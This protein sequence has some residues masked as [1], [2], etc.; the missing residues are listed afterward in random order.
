[1]P[2]HKRKPNYNGAT[3]MQELLT[4]VCDYYGDPVDDRK[5]EDP[6]HINMFNEPEA[7]ADPEETEPIAKA[8]KSGV[9]ARANKVAPI[10]KEDLPDLKTVFKEGWQGLLLPIIILLPFV[11]DYFFKSTFFT[12]RLGKDGAKYMSSSLLIFIGGLASI[13]AVII[14]KDKKQVTPN[15]IARMFADG[16]KTIA[17][18]IGVWVFGYM[19]GA[20]FTDLGV[21]DEMLTFMEGLNMGKFG[22]VVFICFITCQIGL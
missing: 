6:D 10:A 5:Q 8:H 18:A 22:I 16:I 21:T 11:L 9:S 12:E 20:M 15:A 17:P 2:A 14:A 1:M 4:A 13:Y 19:I 3:T 7:F